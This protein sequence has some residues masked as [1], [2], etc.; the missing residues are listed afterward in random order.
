[1][2]YAGGHSLPELVTAVDA[3]ARAADAASAAEGSL[4]ATPR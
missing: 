1:M 4:S 3:A 2:R